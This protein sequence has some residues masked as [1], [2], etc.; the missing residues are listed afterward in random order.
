MAVKL[1]EALEMCSIADEYTIVLP[2]GLPATVA[3]K[4]ATILEMKGGKY[5]PK[6]ESFKFLLSQGTRWMSNMLNK[7]IEKYSQIEEGGDIV[8]TSG[9]VE[10][11]VPFA[12]E[13]AD[14]YVETEE[15]SPEE[16]TEE[17]PEEEKSEETYFQ[18]S[19]DICLKL[20][21]LAGI[22]ELGDVDERKVVYIPNANKGEIITAIMA[23]MR[24]E[25]AL[26][27][28]KI[29]ICYTDPKEENREHMK[30][31]FGTYKNFGDLLKSGFSDMTQILSKEMGA[32]EGKAMKPLNRIILG[33][34]HIVNPNLIK[35]AYGLLKEGGRLVAYAGE[36]FFATDPDA[37][38]EFY[39]WLDEVPEFFRNVEVGDGVA[40]VID[41]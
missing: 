16:E 41:K 3:E 34:D 18:L 14:E 35:H 36:T 9:V 32:A 28:S 15:E 40:I 31:I 20:V 11:G 13:S 21:K 6:T 37:V 29:V 2:Q 30:G 39:T 19:E 38:E 22:N 1:S 33:Y 7:L 24:P 25:V 5:N 12:V 4:L 26:D 17:E 10:E 23:Y 8:E 27:A